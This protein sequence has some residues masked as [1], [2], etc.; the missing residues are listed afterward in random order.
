M[1]AP[2]SKSEI[3]EGHWI[4]RRSLTQGILC[5]SIILSFQQGSLSL[6]PTRKIHSWKVEP[7]FSSNVRIDTSKNLIKNVLMNSSNNQPYLDIRKT[8][9][10]SFSLGV[11][12][13]DAREK[14]LHGLFFVWPFQ[15]SSRTMTSSGLTRRKRVNSLPTGLE[16]PWPI[17]PSQLWLLWPHGSTPP[18][19][20]LR[21][22]ELPFTPHSISPKYK[23]AP[24]F[25]FDSVH[26]Y[27]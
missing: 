14:T 22:R 11:V 17:L 5:L 25:L 6:F 21:L 4:Q 3:N 19:S 9:T 27:E 7:R 12:S 8:R 10:H 20:N 2:F 23:E 13:I 1:I 18:N 26:F 16:F 24:A 15:Q